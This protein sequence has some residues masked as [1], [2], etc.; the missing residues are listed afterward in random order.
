MPE[1]ATTTRDGR[2]L[3]LASIITLEWWQVDPETVAWL[4][5]CLGE[6]SVHVQQ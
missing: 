4:H 3:L 2:Q 5:G 1:L 6:L